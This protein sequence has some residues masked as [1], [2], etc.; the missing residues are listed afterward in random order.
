MLD[1][2]GFYTPLRGYGV[3]KMQEYGRFKVSRTL[4]AIE[5]AITMSLP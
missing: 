2:F 5:G 4:F 3:E 1:M